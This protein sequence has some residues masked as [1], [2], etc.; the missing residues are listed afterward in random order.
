MFASLKAVLGTSL[1]LAGL[2]ALVCIG[3]ARAAT[4]LDISAAEWLH[5]AEMLR[6]R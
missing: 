1:T 5:Q 2:A 3:S 6:G 4:I